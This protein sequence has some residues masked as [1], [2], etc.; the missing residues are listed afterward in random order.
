MKLSAISRIAAIGVL[1]FVAFGAN[2]KDDSEHPGTTPGE[3]RYKGA[4]VPE[5]LESKDVITPGA[6]ALTE[7]EFAKAKKIYFERCA[8]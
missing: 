3:M 7:A 5:Q 6:P 1:L 2:A 8:G 4:P